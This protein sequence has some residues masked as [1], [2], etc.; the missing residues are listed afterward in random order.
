[1]T[2]NS[3]IFIFGFLPL[4]LAAFYGSRA[5]LRGGLRE[6]VCK[7][8]LLLASIVFYA[9][10][11]Y[12]Y[13]P[14]LFG[15]IVLNYVAALYIGQGRFKRVV[16]VLGVVLDVAALAFYKYFNF[17]GEQL[18]AVFGFGFTPL[19]II[20]PLGIS[21]F[22]FSLISYLVD[23]CRGE[24]EA[25]KNLLNVSLWASFFP[26]IISGP[27]VR[28][29]HMF[30]Q[31][32]DEGA[33]VSFA[34]SE[35]PSADL[36]YGARRFVIGLAKKVIIADT[37]GVVVDEIFTAQMTGIDTPTAWLGIICY[38]FQIFF[39]FAGYSD[40]AIGVAAMF[41]FRFK[42][43]FDY[44]YVSKTIGEFWHRWHISLSTWLR[45]YVYFSLG[46]SRRGNVYFNLLVVFLVSGLWHGADWHFVAWGL[47]Y[48]VFMFA[49]RVYRKNSDKLKVPSVVLWLSTMIVVVLGW[50]LFRAEGM[51]QAL[52]YMGNLF[53]IGVVDTQFFGFE[54]YFDGRIAFLLVVSAVCS[55]PVF[56]KMREKYEGTAG[57]EAVRCVGIPA[58]F[59]LAVLFMI[60]SSYSPFLYAQF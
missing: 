20:Q 17:F 40:M 26:K 51:T 18:D 23:V 55:T 6:N 11:A 5:V 38:T 56:A 4:L 30:P 48:A 14:L 3:T 35:G 10:S 22:V 2:L 50:V 39:D 16:V 58:L 57:W 42:E 60:N 43:N 27:I 36:S 47:W 1:M 9:W 44:P 52:T 25:D 21:F 46:G 54:Y 8:V 45:D 34:S 19:S 7:V 49:D 59:V 29:A 28:Y 24:L 41:G 32:D 13:L 33:V 31:R 53:G 12:G 15:L 37:L